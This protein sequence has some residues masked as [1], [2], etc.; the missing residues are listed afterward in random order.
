[1]GSE[2]PID[3]SFGDYLWCELCGHVYSRAAWAAANNR[4][5]NCGASLINARPWEEIR[6]LNPQYP[7]TP[8]EGK[9]YALYG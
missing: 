7:V 8:V 1:M 3:E 6:Q 5:P 4:C 2:N 9:E